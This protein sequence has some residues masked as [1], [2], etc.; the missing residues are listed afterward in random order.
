MPSLAVS[1]GAALLGPVIAFLRE[2]TLR[3]SET[4]STRRLLCFV[5]RSRKPLITGNSR[6]RNIQKHSRES[7]LEEADEIVNE[8]TTLTHKETQL[9]KNRRLVFVIER[10]R[11][12]GVGLE[13]ALLVGIRLR[14]FDSRREGLLGR[15]TGMFGCEGDV[16]SVESLLQLH[17]VLLVFRLYR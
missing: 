5:G 16:F 10:L 12:I 14:L 8:N 17:F 1:L 3:V 4:K 9:W 13:L 7:P 15:K 2:L 11:G 6:I